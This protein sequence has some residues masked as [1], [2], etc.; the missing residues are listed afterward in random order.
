MRYVVKGNETVSDIARKTGA[1]PEEVISINYLTEVDGIRP[2][3]ILEVPGEERK[4]PMSRYQEG[5]EVQSPY[6]DR[7]PAPKP[8]RKEEALP[9]MGSPTP[10]SGI[11]RKNLIQSKAPTK[12]SQTPGGAQAQKK[13]FGN[14]RKNFGKATGPGMM[15][16]PGAGKNA[17]R[18]VKPQAGA[19]ARPSAAGMKGPQQPGQKPPVGGPGSQWM[20]GFLSKRQFL[21]GG[22]VRKA[23]PNVS[24]PAPNMGSSASN[25][26]SQAMEKIKSQGL[27]ASGNGG[28]Q[29]PKF[30]MGGPGI[31][32]APTGAGFNKGGRVGPPDV[33]DYQSPIVEPQPQG[34]DQ[35]RQRQSSLSPINPYPQG[36]LGSGPHNGRAE[37][38]ASFG[39]G[40]DSMLMHVNK[41]E[42]NQMATSINPK[43]GLPEAFAFLA[44][45]PAI[46]SVIGTVASTVGGMVGGGKEGGGGQTVQPHSP[47]Q[48]APRV[49]AIDPLD[50]RREEGAQGPRPDAS[51]RLPGGDVPGRTV[52]PS[53]EQQPSAAPIQPQPD[54][55]VQKP[56]SDPT[57][58]ASVPSMTG[59]PS[60]ADARGMK[61]K[62]QKALS[63]R[64]GGLANFRRRY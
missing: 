37:G 44:A 27:R 6:V 62:K 2:G 49:P 23:T 60:Y 40:G 9:I 14:I 33:I 54:L 64:S 25:L 30:Q 55:T 18:M 5:G 26:Y 22:P 15:G 31:P 1:D 21:G 29:Q 50:K 38:L 53:A 43:T 32:Q 48:K 20:E 61:K 56:D 42:V 17:A 11:R 24:S 7:R 63:F 10:D 12:M 3:D 28:L 52:M 13:S 45:L 16:R 47:P 59:L 35:F 36:E 46:M 4:S 58:I 39:R 8:R 19:A 34:L 51:P 41:D 57:G